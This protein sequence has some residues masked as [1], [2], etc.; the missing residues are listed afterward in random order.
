MP[1]F[2]S[3]VSIGVTRTELKNINEQSLI[4][5]EKRLL[6]EQR[7]GGTVS[8][9]DIDQVF[10]AI[11]KYP[12]VFRIFAGYDCFYG[13][14]TGYD[15]ER[16]DRIER[17][18]NETME[19]IRFVIAEY[20]QDEIYQYINQ[21]LNNN[22]WNDVRVLLHYRTF[23]TPAVFNIILSRF[24]SKIAGALALMKTKPKHQDLEARLAFLTDADFYLTL[25]EADSRYFTENINTIID[26]ITTNRP[27]THRR[28]FFRKL[29]KAMLHFDNIN[30]ALT[31]RINQTYFDYGRTHNIGYG[32]LI[33]GILLFI[34]FL[35]RISSGPTTYQPRQNRWASESE[36]VL[37]ERPYQAEQMH[38]DMQ[39]FV[40]ARLYPLNYPVNSWNNETLLYKYRN[41]FDLPL[42]SGDFQ[43]IKHSD[44]KSISIFNNTL[45]DCIAILYFDQHYN[46]YTNKYNLL[47]RDNPVHIH[48]LYI[49]PHDS[50]K[51]D[52]S[53]YLIRFYMGKRPARFNAYRHYVYPDSAD[54]K[55]SKFTSVDSLLFSRGI[56]FSRRDDNKEPNQDLIITQPNSTAYKLSWTG[57][58]PFYLSRNWTEEIDRRMPD[59][60][61]V[62]KA[63]ILDLKRYNNNVDLSADGDRQIRTFLPGYD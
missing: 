1:F 36:S 15:A 29:L 23:F 63:L 8:K 33:G 20:L 48:A 37:G 32:L 43:S 58:F 34:F 59:S 49:P 21:A 62:N 35:I 14:L 44:K 31:R 2:K 3:L 26:F 27:Y 19:R 38:I 10:N 60:S 56:V 28:A 61:T 22:N 5:I 9:N 4:R 42:F 57:M 16:L 55:F 13:I 40:E 53:M 46:R 11:R 52:F 41:P 54:T 47:D 25:N 7:L 51:V 24:N 6:A 39:N 12:D 18:D 45:N 50:I 30:Y 17:F